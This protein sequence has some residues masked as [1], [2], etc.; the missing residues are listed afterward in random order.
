MRFGVFGGVLDDFTKLNH[1]LLIVTFNGQ[2]A[3]MG[4]TRQDV[5][6]VVL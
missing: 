3:S 2:Q 5:T 4:N 1:R 6:R